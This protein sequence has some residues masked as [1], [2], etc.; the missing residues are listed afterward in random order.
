MLVVSGEE[1]MKN[2]FLTGFSLVN[3]VSFSSVC[4]N[5][6]WAAMTTLDIPF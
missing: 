4:L 2:D 1:I 6:F 5:L 3:A